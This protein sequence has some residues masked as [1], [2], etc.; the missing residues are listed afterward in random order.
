[1][2]WLDFL[3]HLLETLNISIYQSENCLKTKEVKGYEKELYCNIFALCLFAGIS[4]YLS[5]PDY[6]VFNSISTSGEHTRDSTLK[7]VV[8]K[9]TFTIRD[10]LSVVVRNHLKQSYLNMEKNN[11]QHGVS[12]PVCYSFTYFTKF[13]VRFFCK[14]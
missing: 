1:M 5:L 12:R 13:F 3:C 7:V 10:G 8:L 9:S 6:H 2:H 14:S 11:K 4:Y